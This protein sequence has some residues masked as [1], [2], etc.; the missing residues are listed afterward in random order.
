[1][2]RRIAVIVAAILFV[3]IAVIAAFYVAT[4]AYELVSY[5]VC[6]AK[7]LTGIGGCMAPV[8]G[9]LL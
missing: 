9:V 4:A 1:M 5:L 3:V 7:L 2:L 8:P 6:Y